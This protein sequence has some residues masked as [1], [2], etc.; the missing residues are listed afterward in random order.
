MPAADR[1]LGSLETFAPQ[2]S[3]TNHGPRQIFAVGM[4]YRDHSAEIHYA[5][6]GSKYFT[7]FSSSLAPA[8]VTVATHGPETDWETE[9][10]RDD[11]QGGRDSDG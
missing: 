5:A 1:Q 8:N 3:G 7:K 4:N 10:S 11:W 2:I 6:E 9:L